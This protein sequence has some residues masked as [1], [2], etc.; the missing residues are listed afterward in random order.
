MVIGMLDQEVSML[1]D[2]F[3]LL[4]NLIFHSGGKIPEHELRIR[5]ARFLFF[6]EDV[7][8][9]AGVLSGGERMRAGMACLFAANSSP[10][11]LLLDEPTNNLD[12]IS[13]QQLSA[14]I[15]EFSGALMVISHDLDFVN[16]IGIT[17]EIILSPKLKTA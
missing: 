14:A 3:T 7:Y 17:N 12:L 5:L 13:I 16:E 4:Q 10:D 11:L 15:K 8:K 6:N 9:K 2:Q 1:N